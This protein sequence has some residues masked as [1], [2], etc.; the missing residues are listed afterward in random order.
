MEELLTKNPDTD[1]FESLIREKI[2]EVDEITEVNEVTIT[3]DRQTRQAQIR[4][5]VQTDQETIKE[6][7]SILCME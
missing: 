6:E 2:F 5:I 7:V 3:W 4:F 1:S